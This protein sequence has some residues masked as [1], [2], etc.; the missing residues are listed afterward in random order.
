[1]G[2]A[3]L[4]GAFLRIGAWLPFCEME[5]AIKSSKDDFKTI[6]QESQEVATPVQRKAEAPR[7]SAGKKEKRT[8]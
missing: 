3:L 6:L 4:R 7:K 5:L 2:P 1:M 8:D